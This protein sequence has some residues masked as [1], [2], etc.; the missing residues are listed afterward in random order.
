MATKRKRLETILREYYMTEQQ[1]ANL[2]A[3]ETKEYENSCKLSVYASG[4]GSLSFSF[5]GTSGV[6]KG[7]AFGLRVTRRDVD[8]LVER[9]RLKGYS[10]FYDGHCF[11][12]FHDMERIGPDEV[13]YKNRS[14][15]Y[16]KI[17]EQHFLIF[18]ESGEETL[19]ISLKGAIMFWVN[20]ESTILGG[21]K[22]S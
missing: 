12:L 3:L 5:V 15:R 9:E 21:A 1:S 2:K 10:V 11:R 17:H 22:V 6:N 13:Q 18:D 7:Q 4:D 14:W 16:V 20:N 8:A 19:N